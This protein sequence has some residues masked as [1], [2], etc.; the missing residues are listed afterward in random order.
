MGQFRVVTFYSC[1]SSFCARRRISLYIFT[2]L[3]AENAVPCYAVVNVTETL[4]VS[5]LYPSSLGQSN[6]GELKNRHP[7]GSVE[8]PVARQMANKADR[9]RTTF[10]SVIFPPSEPVDKVAAVR[11]FRVLHTAL[12]SSPAYRDAVSGAPY[13]A[14]WVSFVCPLSVKSLLEWSLIV[15]H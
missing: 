12:H 8:V 6:P 2:H 10:C 5:S 11:E 13:F 7:C 9:G 1:Y 3:E 14:V 15:R 4:A